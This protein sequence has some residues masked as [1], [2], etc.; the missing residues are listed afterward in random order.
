MKIADNKLIPI[1]IMSENRDLIMIIRRAATSHLY[2]SIK[3]Q[4][5][6]IWVVT[7]N[8][9]KN[10]PKLF[11]LHTNFIKYTSVTANIKKLY[12]KLILP[13]KASMFLIPYFS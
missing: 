10:Y 13:N 2:T 1:T 12:V 8:F 9:L 11:G 7:L 6:D 5:L 3:A 4:T